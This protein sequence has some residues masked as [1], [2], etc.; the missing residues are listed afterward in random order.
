M[1]FWRY[2]L[3]SGHKKE[4]NSKQN[5][6]YGKALGTSSWDQENIKNCKQDATN[7]LKQIFESLIKV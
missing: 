6:N 4:Q 1:V 3:L 5:Q 2:L 7:P